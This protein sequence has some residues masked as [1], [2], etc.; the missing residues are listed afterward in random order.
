MN[1]ITKP[2]VSSVAAGV[3]KVAHA[4]ERSGIV[5]SVFGG[6]TATEIAAFGGLVIAVL[7]FVVNAAMNFY[8]KWRHL[9]LAE[10]LAKADR[11]E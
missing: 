7:S 2:I 4:G 10:K 11:E 5:L 8:F 9:K 6:L 3:M 1:D